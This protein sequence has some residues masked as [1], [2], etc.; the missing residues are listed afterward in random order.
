V[1]AV[2]RR[3][4]L[5]M[6]A[7][8]N[9]FRLVN[10]AADGAPGLAVD[11]FDDV[12]VIHADSRVVLDAWREPLQQALGEYRAAYARVHPRQAS[13]ERF[14]AAEK[15]WGPDADTVTALEQGRRYVVRPSAGLSVGLFLDTREV[16]AWL[17]GVAGG[18]SVLNLFAYT[19]SFGVSAAAGG[20]ARVLN[21]DLSKSYLDWGAENYALNGLAVDAHD[22]VYG[23]ASD[24]LN[25]FAR[26]QEHFD[27]VIVDPPSFSSTRSEAFSVE[28]D[29]ARLAAAAARVVAPGGI[30]VAATNH[31]GTSDERFD[32]WLRNG[33]QVAGRQGHLEHRWHEPAADFPVAPGHMPYL[34]VRALALD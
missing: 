2:E 13:R 34:K 12:L 32:A 11:R 20:A 21:L 31:A 33:L 24:W 6:R 29:Y 28:R 30:L 8:L 7:D 25:R 17:R 4:G 3:K 9:A 14:D 15:L 10:G 5:A 22:F 16:R 27:M 1:S 18:K 26:R 23:E 19:C